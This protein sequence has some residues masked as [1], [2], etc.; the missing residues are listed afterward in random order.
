MAKKT[1]SKTTS[2]R[3][4][5]TKSGVGVAETWAIH[6]VRNEQWA[7]MP[8]K[9]PLDDPG[10]LAAMRVEFPHKK[11]AT[12]IT[13]VT[14]IRGIF[15]KGTNMFLSVG[16]AGKTGRPKSRRYDAKGTVVPPRRRVDDDGVLIEG[17]A[18]AAPKAS[19]KKTTKKV[20]KKTAK[21]KVVR[22]KS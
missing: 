19:K 22:R 15:N 8:S 4:V 3:E 14:M 13:R 2:T 1:T 20:V 6:L 21:R 7:K 17:T 9:K 10:L 12:T 16:A 18:A 11:D 5:G